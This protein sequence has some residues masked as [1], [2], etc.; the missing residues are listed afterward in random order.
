M[1]SPDH[2]YL[3]VES[4][5]ANPR[6]ITKED[7]DEELKIRTGISPPNDRDTG[8]FTNKFFCHQTTRTMTRWEVIPTIWSLPGSNA[9]SKRSCC[10]GD[11]LNASAES[12][13]SKAVTD[14]KPI[15]LAS[16]ASRGPISGRRCTS[17]NIH[18]LSFIIIYYHLISFTIIKIIYY[19][20][21]IVCLFNTKVYE[22]HI[23]CTSFY[24]I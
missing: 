24:I 1:S 7:E 22:L 19:H 2:T 5:V 11:S 6:I 21:F 14:Q 17:Q 10:Q 9:A 23:N 13:S 8:D 4:D 3:T 18:L 12:F 16:H 15:I 20:L